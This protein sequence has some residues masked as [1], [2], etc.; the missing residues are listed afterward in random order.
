MM[1]DFNATHKTIVIVTFLASIVALTWSGH[2]TA[3][4]IAIGAAL[5]AGLGINVA[6]TQ[7]V[8]EHTN[9]NMAKLLGMVE[10]QARMLAAMTPPK[11]ENAV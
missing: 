10:E 11:D 4:L 7:A 9:G 5:L 2:D 1:N 6:Q 8:K 3:A